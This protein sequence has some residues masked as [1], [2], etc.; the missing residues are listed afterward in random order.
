[1]KE[2][3]LF[4]NACVRRDSR[5][6]R[7]AD[8]L[9]ER[10]NRPYY[11]VRLGELE[12]PAVDECF[13]GTR[14]NLIAGKRFDHPIFTH[15]RTFA[16]AET[17]VIAAPYWDLSFPSALK[18]YLEQVNAVGVTFRYTDKGEPV[19]LCRAERLFY[20]MT[21][22]GAYVPE[23]FGF[24]YVR[25]L[26]QGFY[27]IPDVRLVSARGLDLDGADAEAILRSAERAITV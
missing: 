10:L 5:T 22:G 21:A 23:D 25:A 13:L 20:V 16:Q 26:A 6:K 1:M 18:R 11:E 7:L 24:G 12:F 2:N 27:G 15:A 8:C 19:G 4:V 14:D 17:I 9:L 3:V